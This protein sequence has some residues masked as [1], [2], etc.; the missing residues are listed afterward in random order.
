MLHQTTKSLKIY[1]QHLLHKSS[2]SFPRNHLPGFLRAFA[3]D[4][5]TIPN[6]ET[7]HEGPTSAADAIM[8][9]DTHAAKQAYAQL[10]QTIFGQAVQAAQ[11]A[12]HTS[13]FEGLQYLEEQEQRATAQPSQKKEP[14]YL[15]RSLAA[16]RYHQKM[17][18]GTPRG[19]KLQQNWQRQIILETRAVDAAMARYK[20]EA[21]S[22][23]RRGAG[24]TLPAARKLLVGWFHPLADAIRAEQYRIVTGAPG[25]DRSVYGPYLLRLDPEQLAVIAMHAAINA[26][27]S[28]D[29]DAEAVG[30]APGTCRM[31]KLAT[32]LGRAVEAQHHVNQLEALAHEQNMKRKEV[33]ELYSRGKAL[34]S[35]LEDG[36]EGTLSEQQW[37]EWFDIGHTLRA[38]GEMLPIDHMEWFMVRSCCDVWVYICI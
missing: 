22:A 18:D 11:L 28:P 26:F 16:L 34:R 33:R 35:L 6:P 25:M 32:S 19:R 9:H 31:T 36:G 24:A 17:M 21:E 13:A 4:A 27:M 37:R 14:P 5:V 7:L 8:P 29:P 12:P 20:R 1:I 23:V 10:V 3:A 15:T 30:S 38:Q 2:T